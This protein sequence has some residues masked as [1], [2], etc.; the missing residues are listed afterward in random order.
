[1]DTVREHWIGVF[2]PMLNEITS[3]NKLVLARQFAVGDWFCSAIADLVIRDKTLTAD[4]AKRLRFETA[5]RIL[6]FREEWKQLK[7]SDATNLVNN[8]IG[9]ITSKYDYYNQDTYRQRIAHKIPKPPG[10]PPERL[11]QL[12]LAIRYCFSSELAGMGIAEKQS[13][14]QLFQQ[15]LDGDNGFPNNTELTTSKMNALQKP[16]KEKVSL[17]HGAHYHELIVLQVSLIYRN[18]QETKLYLCRLKI[19]SSR[20]IRITSSGTLPSSVK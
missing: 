19:S 3:I 16:E 1:M 11:H 8:M 10:I 13:Y 17:R 20:S 7:E 12:D 2:S 14:P 18:K 5:F 6:R 9:N 4:E 15:C